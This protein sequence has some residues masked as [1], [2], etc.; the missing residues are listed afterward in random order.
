MIEV[1]ACQ[2][3]YG[4]PVRRLEAM[5]HPGAQC[6]EQKHSPYSSR[7]NSVHNHSHA[8]DTSRYNIHIPYVGDQR[9]Q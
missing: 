1:A 9:W 4:R 2:F 6:M 3:V 8:L 5:K 7:A